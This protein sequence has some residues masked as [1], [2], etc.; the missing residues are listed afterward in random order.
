M[1]VAIDD[2]AKAKMGRMVEVYIAIG[3]SV[4]KM[5]CGVVLKGKFGK[6]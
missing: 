6:L 3:G 1:T 5:G 4:K 2:E